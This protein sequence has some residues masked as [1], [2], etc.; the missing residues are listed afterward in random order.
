ML[1][2]LGLE[3]FVRLFHDLIPHNQPHPWAQYLMEREGARLFFMPTAKKRAIHDACEVFIG[4]MHAG[5][6]IDGPS[7]MSLSL[8]AMAEYQGS[9][10]VLLASTQHAHREGMSIV[11]RV[12]RYSLGMRISSRHG[13]SSALH[14]ASSRNFSR[15]GH[16]ARIS[17]ITSI[18]MAPPTEGPPFIQLGHTECLA[19]ALER[20]Y[21]GRRPPRAQC[22]RPQGGSDDYRQK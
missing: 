15:V 8:K 21:T 6:K 19:I 4:L 17:A 22:S 7:L 18:T 3:T 13:S 16:F 2:T 5:M 1:T 9:Q 14:H 12:K 11:E 20:A 10:E